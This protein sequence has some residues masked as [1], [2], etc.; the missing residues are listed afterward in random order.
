MRG[1]SAIYSPILIVLRVTWL[2]VI[3]IS[4]ALS[5]ETTTPL[6][7]QTSLNR[8]M[9]EHKKIVAEYLALT[10]EEAKIF[11]PIYER[12]RIA[13][14]GLID[15]R[16]KYIK[17][18]ADHY[19]S[20]DDQLSLSFIDHF[21]KVDYGSAQL[22]ETY[23]PK[24]LEVIGPKKTARFYQLERRIRIYLDAEMSRELPLLK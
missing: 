15:E 23:M 5:D 24:F 7:T 18:L 22:W 6:I 2:C 16:M 13:V 8:L 21:R 4:P 19:E 12:Y 11:W 17:E 9:I 14:Q 10:S 20:I 1:I 3:L